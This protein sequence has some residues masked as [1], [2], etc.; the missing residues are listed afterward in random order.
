MYFNKCYFV[1]FLS[2]AFLFACK[3]EKEEEETCDKLWTVVKNNSAAT[4]KIENGKMI[5]D[6][7]N[8]TGED[9][10]VISQQRSE[11]HPG[12]GFSTKI[13]FE[14]F[15]NTSASGNAFDAQIKASFAYTYDSDNPVATMKVGKYGSKGETDQTSRVAYTQNDNYPTSGELGMGFNDTTGNFFA[16]F[17]ISPGGMNNGN[18]AISNVQ[19]D[20]VIFK[21]SVGINNTFDGKGTSQSVHVELDYINFNFPPVEL[22]N[23]DFECNSLK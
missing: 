7:P 13:M 4:V 2:I 3:K 21:F 10:V 19:P 6:V 18:I 12:K 20:P 9:D 14:N 8:P 5:I 15:T 11:Y 1:I 22:Q 16:E 23:D 17:D